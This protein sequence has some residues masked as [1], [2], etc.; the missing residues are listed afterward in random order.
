MSVI[1]HV[2]DGGCMTDEAIREAI[3]DGC[4][5]LPADG[6]K[7]LFLV[8]DGTRSMPMS[9]VFRALCDSLAGRAAQ[10]DFLIALGTHQPM[11][12]DAILKHFGLSAEERSGVYGKVGI[13]NHAWQDADQLTCIGTISEDEIDAISE[14]RMRQ[15]VDV[16]INKRVLDYDVVCV[17]GP[18]FPHE[19]VG[20]SGGN[21]YFFPGVAGPEILNLF[22]WLGALI[23]NYSINGTKNTPVRAVVD[24]AASF[25]PVEKY[26]F[27]LTVVG[28]ETRAV[29]F[30]RPEESWSAAADLSS[31]A[32]IVYKDKPFKQVLAIAPPMYDDIWVAGKCMYK[33]EPVIADGGEL[34]IYAPHVT[35]VSY[36][37]GDL[38]REIG[39]HTRDYFTAQMEKFSHIPGGILAHSTHVRGGGTYE[40]GVEK[41][42]VT[43]T[44][45]TGIPEEACHAISLAYRDHTTINPEDF[46]DR[47]DEGILLVPRAGEILYRL[48]EE[49]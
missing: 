32:H 35:E 39:Y 19:V 24:K 13:Y 3:Q 10:V 47:E 49:Q 44:L 5:A 26:S 25:I 22:H 12:E 15:S 48:R 4:A 36:T 16:H 6:K 40:D 41:C 29:F 46:A 9:T 18:V 37:H 11:P 1:K 31:E 30:G 17:A 21:K 45:A 42:R 8:P 34:I 14:G 33:L 2:S 28:K 23:T 20:F 27:C 38:I 7:V 43:V